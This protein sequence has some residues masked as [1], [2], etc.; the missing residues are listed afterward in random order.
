MTV[1]LSE[2]VIDRKMQGMCRLSYPNHPRGCPNFD[3]KRGC[4]PAVPL[5]SEVFDLSKPVYAIVNSFNLAEHVSR[6]KAAHPHWTDRQLACCLYWQPTARNQLKAEIARFRSGHQEYTVDT[7]PE[8]KGVNVTETLRRAGI[9]LEWP[10]VQC[11]RQVA[12][13]GV[14][15]S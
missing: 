5:F 14:A 7:C 10:P 8:A 11:V 6:M 2:V 9:E 1:L 13:A 12:L 15:R 3:H 4:P